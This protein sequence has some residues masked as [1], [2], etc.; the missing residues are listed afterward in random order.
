[1]GEQPVILEGAEN[2]GAQYSLYSTVQAL[3]APWAAKTGPEFLTARPASGSAQ[4]R[5]P[6]R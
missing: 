3:A 6:R 2:E 4:G 5:S 1:M